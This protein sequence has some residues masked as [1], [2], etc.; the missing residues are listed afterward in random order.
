MIKNYIKT[1]WRS[2]LKNRFFSLLNISGLAVSLA[3]AVLLITYGRQELGFN[4]Q[5]EQEANIY[6]V[7]MQ[8][9]AEY[10]YEKWA[11]LPN[12]V[13]PAML[14]DI[15]EVVS[16]TRLVRRGFTGFGSV[17]TNGNNFIEKNIYLTD[18]A[19]FN[20][21]DVEFTEGSPSTAFLHPRSIVISTSKKDKFFGL[22]PALNKQIIINQNDTLTVSGVFRDLPEN[23]SFDG[24]MFTNMLDSWMGSDVYWSNASYHTYCLLHPNTDPDEV[25]KKATALID[26]YV[27]KDDQYYTDFFLQPLADMYLYS[28]GIKD[29]L[30]SRKGSISAART[31]LILSLLIVFIACINYMNLATARSE[32]NAKEVGVNKVMGASR[33]QIKLRFY[34]ETA[35]IS[36]ISIILGLFLALLCLPVF[37]GTIGT[38]LSAA[39]LFSLENMGVFLLIWLVITFVGGSYPALMMA[40]ISSLSLMRN[41]ATKSLAAQ[42]LRKGLVVF[43]FASSIVLI[44]GVIVISLQM[45]YVNNKDLGY[46]PTNT[47]VVPMHA[48]NTTEKLN[49]IRQAIQDLTGTESI[50]LVQAFPGYGESGRTIHRPGQSSEGLPVSTSVS[51]GAVVPTLGLDLLAGTD[52]P[53]HLSATDSTGY[54]L[55]NEVVAAYLGYE[56]PE[57]AVGQTLA[58]EISPHTTIVGV[59]RNFNYGSLRDAIGGYV[60]SRGNQMN[61]SERYFLVRYNTQNVTPYLAQV[62]QIFN[63]QIPD[64]AFD[65]QFLDDHIKSYYTAENRTNN[66]ITIFSVLTIFI[67]CLG[68]FGLAAF[69]AEQRKKEIGVR[70]VLGASVYKIVQL[71]SGHF[72]GLVLIALLIAGPI[73]WWI[74]SHWL[75]DFNERIAI[76]WW[77]FALAG[78]F[79]VGIALLTVG[80]QAIRAAVANP[81][82]SLRDE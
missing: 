78:L 14:A 73:A 77:S 64:A 65:Y 13:G 23:S 60:Y 69:T 2:L 80:Y 76:P 34:L 19:F 8:A 67:A 40:N 66:I 33:G 32:H 57:D 10:N 61:E 22:E 43:Q 38:T 71:L 49:H 39:Q 7:Y 20:L 11:N 54:I 31:V 17:R 79:S 5:F 37:N 36:L 6:R 72:L 12:S 58:T 1:A 9:N 26:K 68:L 82:D 75:Q 70:K 25:A 74:F 28:A 48:I 4:K 42:Y 55:V 24:D 44:I 50:A 53:D 62:Q 46:Q 41:L 27:A 16:M 29:T 63:S 45:R 35:I 81:V 51:R 15:P 21:F 52:L 3:V 47:L 18:S 30:S 59:V 56:N